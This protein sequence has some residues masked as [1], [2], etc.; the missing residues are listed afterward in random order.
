MTSDDATATLAPTGPK[1]C[2]SQQAITVLLALADWKMP[3]THAE[4][5]A[6]TDIQGQ[7]LS[8]TLKGLA[9]RGLAVC[10][11]RGPTG[12]WHLAHWPGA[13]KGGAS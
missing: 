13:P 6:I 8:H 12:K 10:D 2:G 5:A 11:R 9:E 4:L 3:C 1:H 7:E